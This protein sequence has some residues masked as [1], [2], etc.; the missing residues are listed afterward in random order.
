[1]LA[2]LPRLSALLIISLL[3]IL[4]SA[5]PQAL[6]AQSAT[7]PLPPSAKLPAPKINRVGFSPIPKF[8]DVAKSLGLTVSHISSGEKRYI[9]ESISGGVGLFDED[10]EVAR[11][12]LETEDFLETA[13]ILETEPESEPN[14]G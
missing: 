13:Q 8:V 7:V 10:L 14:P 4:S 6:R 5:S 11:A 12:L 2:Y 3:L 9:V 1:M